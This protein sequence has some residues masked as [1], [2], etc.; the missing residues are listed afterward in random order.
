MHTVFETCLNLSCFTFR[1]A[2]SATTN[3]VNGVRLTMGPGP[4]DGYPLI[5]SQQSTLWKNIPGITG[6]FP[7]MPPST[8]SVPE[9][10]GHFSSGNRNLRPGNGPSRYGT[11][12]GSITTEFS[13]EMTRT[14]LSQQNPGRLN[15][16][17]H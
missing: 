12:A 13:K 15:H 1:F 16:F 8:F 10:T 9:L 11:R 5:T 6:P 4:S 3:P 14:I 17:E 7:A 2:S